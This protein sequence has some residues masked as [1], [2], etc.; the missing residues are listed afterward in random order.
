MQWYE[1]LADSIVHGALQNEVH[2]NFL[3]FVVI[4]K[5]KLKVLKHTLFYTLFWVKRKVDKIR[6]I[7]VQCTLMLI[8]ERNSSNVLFNRNSIPYRKKGYDGL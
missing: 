7:K 8:C 6:N 1:N 3:R 4:E 5:Q 2:M